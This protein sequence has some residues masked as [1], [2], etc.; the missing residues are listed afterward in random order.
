MPYAFTVWGLRLAGDVSSHQ[1][2]QSCRYALRR[3]RSGLFATMPYTK[4]FRLN[5]WVTFFGAILTPPTNNQHIKRFTGK[6]GQLR[7][8]GRC[9]LLLT[10]GW[11][12]YIIKVTSII[13]F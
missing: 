6:Q 8:L 13:I 1:V 11:A 3:V 4:T 5:L 7:N 2:K 12:L 9:T 10:S